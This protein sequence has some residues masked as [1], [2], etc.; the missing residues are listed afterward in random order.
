[1]SND[2]LEKKIV[3]AMLDNQELKHRA[4]IKSEWFADALMQ[5]VA[6]VILTME[7]DFTD[8]S[9][10]QHEIKTRHPPLPVDEELLRALR[11]QKMLVDDF[12]ASCLVLK[13]SYLQRKLTQAS[14]EFSRQPND[15]TKDN[16]MDW[17]IAVENAEMPDDFGG[18]DQDIEELLHSLENEV[19]GGLRTYPLV[20]KILNDGLKGGTLFTLGARP[21]VGKSAYAVNLAK[22]SLD[23][24]ENTH[25]DLFTLEMTKQEMLKR[26][27]S[28]MTGINNYKFVNAKHNLTNQEKAEVIAAARW[29]DQSGLRIHD[30]RYKLSEIER[31]IRHSVHNHNGNYLAIVDYL[32]LIDAEDGRMQ[33]REQIGKITRRMKMLTN[34]LDIPIVLLSQLSR[35]VE[36]RD[37]NEPFLSDLRESGDVEQDSS[38][39]GF[40]YNDDDQDHIV[41]LKIAKNRSGATGVIP[42]EFHKA[43]TYFEELDF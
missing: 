13:K 32:G 1:M 19:E 43:S 12:K 29:V 15:M 41:N 7:E 34:E 20:D 14:Q 28:L 30:S 25:V 36:S 27:V 26:M 39:V 10:V 18:L 38:V 23:N 3:G 17:L 37:S 11:F 4:E 24:N 40:L 21:A 2:V 6:D 22:L 8:L 9:E 42:Y 5:K 31:M 16:L 35:A 33:K